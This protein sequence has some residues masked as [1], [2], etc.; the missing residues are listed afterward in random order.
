MSCPR[1]REFNVKGQTTITAEHVAELNRMLKIFMNF[2]ELEKES[3]G[4]RKEI[5]MN[6]QSRS[7]VFNLILCRNTT[8]KL[9]FKNRIVIL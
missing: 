5:S 2:E 6:C 3:Y 1:I 8:F 4:V 9:T 7:R